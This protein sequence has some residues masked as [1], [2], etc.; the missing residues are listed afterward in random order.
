[1][2]KIS[3]L[4]LILAGFSVNHAQTRSFVSDEV[5]YQEFLRSG[6]VS[7]NS[8]FIHENGI[9]FFFKGKARTV[10]VAGDFNGWVPELLME[11]HENGIWTRTWEDRLDAGTYKYKLIIDDIWV[12]DPFNTNYITDSS[13]QRVSVFTLDEDFIPNK[14]YPLWLK[15]D[16]YLFQFKD[17]HASQVALVGDFNNWDPFS[18]PL[19][20]MGAGVFEIKIRLKPGIHTYCFVVDDEWE[21][22]PNNLRQFSDETGA[23]INVIDIKKHK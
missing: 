7:M 1:M 19:K 5:R 8:P 15:G 21:P 23:I 22:D 11:K 6:D 18:H 16:T 12:E 14:K 9:V 3:V 10:V 17:I 13:G 20:Y 2:K 4:L